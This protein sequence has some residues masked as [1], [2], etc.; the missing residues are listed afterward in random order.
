MIENHT[1]YCERLKKNI[2]NGIYFAYLTSYTKEKKFLKSVF[3]QYIQN[4]QNFIFEDSII[5]N[6]KLIWYMYYM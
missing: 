1:R 5:S 3:V 6:L 2:C 4:T